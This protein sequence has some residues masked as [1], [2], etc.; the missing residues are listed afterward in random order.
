MQFGVSYFGVRNPQHFQRD[1]EEIHAWG[2]P[3]SSSP[4][5]KRITA[6]GSPPSLSGVHQQGLLVSIL[7]VCGVFGGEALASGAGTRRATTPKRWAVFLLCPNSAA[8]AYLQR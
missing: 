1:L 2:S 4:S 3:R 5:P 6:T 8:V 7:G